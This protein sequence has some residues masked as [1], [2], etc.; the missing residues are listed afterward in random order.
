MA[1]S[2]R[3]REI[4]LRRQMQGAILEKRHDR[5]Y[6]ARLNVWPKDFDEAL[7]IG[8]N[9]RRYSFRPEADLSETH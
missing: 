7:T 2:N 8:N 3:R 9:P 5:L 6:A 1:R 4:H